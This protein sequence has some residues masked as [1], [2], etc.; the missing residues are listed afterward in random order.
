MSEQEKN[1]Q[2][3]IEET[4]ISRVSEANG[5]I[6]TAIEKAVNRGGYGL[7]EV[8]QLEI[9]LTVVEKATENLDTIQKAL[10]KRED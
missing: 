3:T 8:V 2:S 9:A 6:R 4:N 1:T 10:K 5:I 7:K